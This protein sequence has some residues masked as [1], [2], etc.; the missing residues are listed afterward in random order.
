MF[1]IALI[2][3]VLFA[4]VVAVS[5][6]EPPLALRSGLA[7]AP[8]ADDEAAEAAL[9]AG[10]PALIRFAGAPA[11]AKAGVRVAA[12]LGADGVIA[13]L[14]A[15]KL[16]EIRALPGVAWVGPYAP[17]LRIAPEIA[18]LSKADPR[19]VVPVTLHVFAHVD[20]DALAGRLAGL[21]LSV[22]GKRAGQAARGRLGERAG[23]LVLTPSP[24]QL[25][26]L[27]ERIAAWPETLWLDRRPYWGLLNDASSWVGQSGLD[28]GQATPVHDRG[29]RGE[30][31][32]VCVLDTGMD[33]DSCYFR[34]EAQG[35]PPANV[36]FGTGTPSPNQRKVAIVNFLWDED[37]PA[38]VRDWDN[39]GHGTHV[40]GSV[41]GDD[42][43]TPGRRDSGDGMAPGARLIVQDGG[44]RTDDCADMPAIGCPAAALDPFF[45]QALA[46]GA[47]IHTNSWGDREN[48]TPYNIYSEGSEDAD[49]FMWEHPEV[50]LVFAAGN[51]GPGVD[52]VAS[53][54]T[55][56]NVLAVGATQHGAG[57]GDIASFSSRGHT[58][59]DRVKPDVTI[60]GSSVVSAR[61]DSDVTTNNCNTTSMSGTSMAA[62][63][64]AGSAAL[65]RQ[66]F[67]AGYYPSG[68]AVAGDAFAPS[69]ALTKATMIASAMPMEDI[70]APPPS[71]DQGWGRI[72]LDDALYFPGDALRLRVADVAPGFGAAG[73]DPDEHTFDVLDAGA[74]LKVTLVWTDYPSSP[75]AATHLVNDLDLELV[76]PGG[77]TYLGNV[78]SGGV[79]V[80]GGVPDARNNVEMVKLDAAS[81]GAWT[82]RVRARVLPQPTQ[83]YALVV[84]GGVAQ[85]GVAL[86]RTAFSYDDGIGGNGDG[87]L[88]PGEWAD[89]SV[90]VRNVGEQAATN[91]RVV[92]SSLHPNLEVVVPEASVPDLASGESAS[93]EAPRLRVRVRPSHPCNEPVRLKLT[94]L[95]AGF[96]SGEELPLEVGHKRVILSEDFESP[97]LWHHVAAES[98]AS[99]GDWLVGDPV[100][101]SYQPENDASPAPGVNCFYTDENPS[102]G[103]GTDDVDD[104]VAVA[105]SG[106]YD[107]SGEPEARLSLRRW[108]AHRDL[109]DDAEDY[110]KLEIRENASAADVL[111]EEL[112]SN[113]TA[114]GW[115]EV[116]FRVA[117]FVTPGPAIELKVSA[118]DGPASGN[119]VEAAIDEIVFWAPQ[120]AVH[121][122]APQ[123]VDDLAVAVAG[124]GADLALSW[125][126][127][128]VDPGH[129]EPVEY[130]VYRSLQIQGGYAEQT[131][132]ADPGDELAWT[133][134]GA[135]AASPALYTYEVIVTNAAGASDVLP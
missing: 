31:Q 37:D 110:Y 86:Q 23:R 87:V 19:S 89:L 55:A 131:R 88:E 27:R 62:P 120:C 34:D 13:W 95:A 21:G 6:A 25:T 101:T 5:A 125:G 108:F 106:A 17:E 53:P 72:T 12:H 117:D 26:A 135:A 51:N 99:T 126:R 38:D 80:T 8:A 59:D 127:P 114:P 32:V 132:T 69:A 28:R 124:G 79:S 103:L 4:A 58:D 73:G 70:T 61:N 47:H 45:A 49:V 7:H 15:G 121:D 85:P 129:G 109:G 14:P 134:A 10:G 56:K 104:G 113:E 116:S 91:V 111:L 18:A 83:G 1:R 133:D 118:S 35:L 77:E 112:G 90:T 40:A 46:Q 43:A 65:V 22:R 9:R 92:A 98:T 66:Y 71:S 93:T 105:R 3:S 20:V 29:I 81:A 36:G 107:L 24:A 74:P 41:A 30:G 78:F 100:G 122:P 67:D 123:V 76:G 94:L 97:T 130:V 16:D 64:A 75:A 119:L 96:E 102:G 48:F 42:F 57:A 33:A 68:V 44:Y 128:G 39:Q 63:T 60:P 52:T 115:T 2:V 82:A 84:T 11:L 50:L 54:A